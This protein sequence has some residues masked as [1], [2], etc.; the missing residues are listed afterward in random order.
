MAGIRWRLLANVLLFIGVLMIFIIA[1]T[2]VTKTALVIC[3]GSW[4][5]GLLMHLIGPGKEDKGR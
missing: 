1:E 2:G 3:A 5:V 4:A